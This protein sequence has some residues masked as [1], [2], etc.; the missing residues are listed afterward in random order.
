MRIAPGAETVDADTRRGEARRLLVFGLFSEFP[1][2]ALELDALAD[3]FPADAWQEA[4]WDLALKTGDGRK[5]LE[6]FD[7]WMRR[8]NIG[9]LPWLADSLRFQLCMMSLIPRELRPPGFVTA[10]Y[11]AGGDLVPN[12]ELR[13]RSGSWLNQFRWAARRLV[14]R[15]AYR[16]IAD[17]DKLCAERGLG[18]DAIRKAV[19]RVFALCEVA[20]PCGSSALPSS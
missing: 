4:L 11:A 16:E 15:E 7:D 20:D 19:I 8:W 14:R 17:H 5:A 2:M 3:D 13:N 10:P 1:G 6:A 18:E 9:A 12:P